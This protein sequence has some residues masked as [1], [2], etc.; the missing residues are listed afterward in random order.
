MQWRKDLIAHYD[1]QPGGE[2]KQV[3]CPITKVFGPKK[4]RTAPHIVPWKLGYDTMG[5]LFN[6]EGR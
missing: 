2:K 6:G 5:E 3:W 1:A 4:S